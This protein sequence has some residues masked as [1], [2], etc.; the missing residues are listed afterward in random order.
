M[1]FYKQLFPRYNDRGVKFVRRF[2]TLWHRVSSV[3]VING[4]KPLTVHADTLLYNRLIIVISLKIVFHVVCVYR[5]VPCVFT[6][7]HPGT[8]SNRFERAPFVRDTSGVFIQ[9]GGELG[10]Y[11]FPPMSLK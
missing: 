7:T 3:D 1:V 9:K 8:V 6:N 11:N 2:I 4:R 10:S 5:R